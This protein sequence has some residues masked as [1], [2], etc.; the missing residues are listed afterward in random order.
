MTQQE[1][2]ARITALEARVKVADDIEEIQKLMATYVTLMNSLQKLDEVM[3]LYTEDAKL[4]VT[5]RGETGE[6]ER[7]LGKYDGK[8]AIRG[9]YSDLN[10]A[11]Y[12]Y[13]AHHIT[14]PFITVDGDKA[15]GRWYLLALITAVT[16]GSPV[17]WWEQGVYDLEFA[18]IDGKWRIS[19]MKF[20]YNFS[21]PY[22]E[23]WAKASEIQ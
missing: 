10:L 4:V 18:K 5:T 17:G 23:G 11:N 3:A 9:V 22:E 15:K 8:E 19:A 2:E 13:M 7:F 6:F 14:N 16:A 12:S 20:E 1:L 21:V